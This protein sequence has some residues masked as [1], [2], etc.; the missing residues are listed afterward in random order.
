M[1]FFLFFLTLRKPWAEHGLEIAVFFCLTE[2]KK[3]TDGKETVDNYCSLIWM[4][5]SLLGYAEI[6]ERFLITRNC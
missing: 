2:N 1:S 5:C 4:L 6:T 3:D